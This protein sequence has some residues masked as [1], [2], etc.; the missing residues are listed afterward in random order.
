MS[1]ESDLFK[2]LP[3]ESADAG[4]LFFAPPPPPAEAPSPE[5]FD[6]EVDEVAEQD[7]LNFNQFDDFFST[8][9]NNVSAVFTS[10]SLTYS[11]DSNYGIDSSQYS[12]DA[13]P[14]VTSSP[15]DF[16]SGSSVNNG[17]YTTHDAI[18]SA[19]FSNSPLPFLPVNPVEA[20][21]DYETSDFV[22]ISPGDLSVVPT[23]LSVNVEP[24]SVVKTTQVKPFKCPQC[25]FGKDSLWKYIIGSL[26]LPAS[27][28]KHNLKTH[29]ETHN[30]ERSK[31]FG[32]SVCR[33]RFSRKHDLHRHRTTM[34]G[35][36]TSSSS[37]S[38]ISD[39]HF[40]PKP[41]H[42]I[43]QYGDQWLTSSAF[44]DLFT[45]LHPTGVP[46]DLMAWY[47]EALLQ[48]AV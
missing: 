24:D 18:Y 41:G 39:P 17:L 12:Y 27:A 3:S 22:G 33:R 11:T 29:I 6:R 42:D 40:D 47:N 13:P 9:Y 36:T 31:P 16:E 4:L 20:R 37:V 34:H 23:P 45:D 15:S 46:E 25:P 35:D 28:R 2:Y 7:P 38:S 44:A 19:V 26:F 5:S 43:P 1:P 30:K 21:S 14:S 48:Q 32:C 8:F 10:P